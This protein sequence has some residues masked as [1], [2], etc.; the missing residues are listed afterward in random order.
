MKLHGSC[1]ICAVAQICSFLRKRN[2]T[3]PGP[4]QSVPLLLL[5]TSHSFLSRRLYPTTIMLTSMDVIAPALVP[6]LAARVVLATPRWE[7]RY[8]SITCSHDFPIPNKQQSSMKKWK[9]ALQFSASRKAILY[10]S[11]VI[12]APF[13]S[14]VRPF[15]F[16]FSPPISSPVLSH[17]HNG[18]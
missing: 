16:L 5:H 14:P 4:G 9:G 8:L 15:L 17:H 2:H 12:R 11:P 3:G 13:S 10:A 1:C 6:A 18:I 7:S